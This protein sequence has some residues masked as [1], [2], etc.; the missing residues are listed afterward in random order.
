MKAKL[1]L[2]L[3]VVCGMLRA[4]DLKVITFNIR[5]ST[6]ADGGN[7]WS[8]RKGAVV[9]L[10]DYYHPDIF[11][12]QEALPEQMDD[13]RE[14]L[15]TYRAVGV[16]RDDGDKE[17]EFSALF[18]DS[19][20]FQILNSGTFWLSET[21]EKVSMGW[22]AACNR[23][24]TYALLKNKS[25]KQFWVFN[26]HFDHVG[27]KAR[28]ESAKLI[29]EKIKELNTKNLP[30]VLTGDF[31]LHDHSQ[32]IKLLSAQLTDTYYNSINKPYGPKG[33]FTGFDISK[34]PEDRI[35]YIF[36]ERFKVK[37]YRVIDDRRQNLLYPSDHFP[38]MAELAF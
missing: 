35:D 21:P 13:L 6:E 15:K 18:Y 5:M 33:T 34:E 4:Q 12:V 3:I 38:V 16:G 30:V 10:L 27:E 28:K 7:A 20:K 9:E 25:G 29:L 14:G 1:A 11:G 31:N 36:V 37:S 23:I 2:V 19:E 24:C 8:K 22:D 17:G 26:T 32:P